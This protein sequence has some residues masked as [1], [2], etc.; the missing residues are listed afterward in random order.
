MKT[1]TTNEAGGAEEK[2]SNQTRVTAPRAPPLNGNT[3]ASTE[4]AGLAWN[5]DLGA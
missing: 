1:G 4:N 5:L 2:A 3:E